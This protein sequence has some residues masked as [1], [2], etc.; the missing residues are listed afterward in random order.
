MSKYNA[1]KSNG[2]K[3]QRSILL[4]E[5]GIKAKATLKAY[6]NSLDQFLKFSKVNDYDS[7]IK[8][9]PKQIQIIVEDFLMVCKT[10]YRYWSIDNIFSAIQLFFTMNDVMLN[11]K[12]IIKNRVG[13]Y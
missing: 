7:L 5:C 9:D 4:F 2:L 3:N 10:K 11:F 1:K 8:E 13:E 12:K 6:T